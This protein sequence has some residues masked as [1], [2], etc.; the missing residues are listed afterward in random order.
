MSN[1]PPV[2]IE[3]QVP[4]PFPPAAYTIGTNFWITTEFSLDWDNPFEE[5]SRTKATLVALENQMDDAVC[6]LEGEIDARALDDL[7]SEIQAL[8]G[9]TKRG[10]APEACSEDWLVLY[11]EVEH[12]LQGRP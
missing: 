7:R 1:T 10:K 6:A 9:R 2:P 12:A 11:S 4:D 5:V 3:A 8:K